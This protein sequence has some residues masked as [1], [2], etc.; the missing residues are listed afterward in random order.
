MKAIAPIFPV[1]GASRKECRL[2][3]SA[4]ITE[5]S[6]AGLTSGCGLKAGPDQ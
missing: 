3:A 1:A 4:S 6:A 2:F 5:S